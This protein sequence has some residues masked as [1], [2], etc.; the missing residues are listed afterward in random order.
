MRKERGEIMSIIAF[1]NQKGG[2]GKS[3]LS[4]NIGAYLASTGKKVLFVDLDAQAT[5]TDLTIPNEEYQLS[6]NDVLY[7]KN[8]KIQDAIVHTDKYDV[9]PS[10]INMAN[11]DSKLKKDSLDKVLDPLRSQYDYIILDCPPAL[12]MM[13]IAALYATDKIISVIKPDIVSTR[14][15]TLLNQTII[16]EVP[17]K[18]IN[19]VIINQYKK[20][21]ISELTA[22]LMKQ[23]YPVLD[24]LVRDT[25]VLS[26]SAS[27]SQSI[28]DY[29]KNS[30]GYQDIK[31]V[32]NE[33]LAKGII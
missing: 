29:A 27:I 1:I 8:I 24:T 20:R 9:L 16:N 13:N 14:G 30:N 19:A 3:I 10:I 5:L 4:F 25:S 23:E 11:I 7:N 28:V 15:L 21:K 31:D 6:L 17:G 32:T 22:Q 12:G 2:V 18:T 33:L 26:E